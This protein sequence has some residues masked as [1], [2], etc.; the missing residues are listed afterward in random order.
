MNRTKFNTWLKLWRLGL[1]PDPEI[2]STILDV[3]SEETEFYE[4]IS[5]KAEELQPIGL[6]RG[7]KGLD[8]PIPMSNQY[9]IGPEEATD[10]FTSF[11]NSKLTDLKKKHSHRNFVDN[12]AYMGFRYWSVSGGERPLAEWRSYWT[13]S[14][15]SPHLS[16]N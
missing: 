2:V 11:V 9:W 15:I 16:V 13:E 10:L 8:D 7:A 12:E 14:A 5:K 3:S 6:I 4:A 1:A